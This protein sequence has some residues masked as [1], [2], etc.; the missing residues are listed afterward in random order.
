MKRINLLSLFTVLLIAIG[1]S[2]CSTEPIDSTFNEDNTG[3][4]STSPANFQVNIGADLYQTSTASGV[5]ADNVLTITATNSNGAKFTIVVPAARGAYSTAMITYQPNSA[6]AGVYTNVSTTGINGTVNIA[7][8]NATTHRV[9]GTFNFTGYWSNASDNRPSANFTSGVFTN[10]TFTDGTTTPADFTFTVNAGSNLFTAADTE[11]TLGIGLIRI[12]GTDAQGRSMGI[13]VFGTTTGT[14]TGDQV[15]LAYIGAENELLD[16]GSFDDTAIVE[17]TEIDTVNHTY[18]GTFS[19]TG[20]GD[21]DTDTMQFTNGVFTDVPYTTENLDGDMA[22]SIIDGTSYDYTNS[23]A[24]IVTVDTG[25][26]GSVTFPLVGPDH[27][28]TL[29]LSTSQGVGNY[30]ITAG[31]ANSVTF[32]DA[33]GTEY[34]VA[35]GTIGITSNAGNRIAGTYSVVV[36]NDA[37]ETLHTITGTFDV[38]YSME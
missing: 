26:S 13:Q 32:K 12:L 11:A 37:G 38:D 23:I 30:P 15:I 22:T 1:L 28:I 33:A 4:G 7:S 27:W 17:I 31:G 34:D 19:F 10:L 6:E 2:A 14:Y 29:S 25:S 16:Y 20:Q 21:D 36:K 35:E 3:G 8:Y 9:S 24:Y 5:V 18:T